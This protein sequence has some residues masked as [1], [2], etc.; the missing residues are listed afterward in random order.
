MTLGA[1]LVRTT[2]LF[3][4]GAAIML[5]GS[6]RKSVD[7]QR[8]RAI[9]FVGFFVIV[10]AVVLFGFAGTPGLLAIAIAIVLGGAVEARRAWRLIPAPRPSWLITAAFAASA[11]FIYVSSRADQAAVVWIFMVT[12]SFDG[13]GQVIGQL[14]GRRPLVPNISPAK[15]V[16]GLAGAIV[17]AVFVAVWLRALPGYDVGRTIVVALAIGV[18][19]LIGDLLGSW[20]KRRAGIK[21]FSSVLPGQGG[22]I[23]RFNSFVSAMALVGVWL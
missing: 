1:L 2:A 11:V 8:A 19:S 15:T 22:V 17:G 18:A 4:L 7:V 20:T 10:H 12:A 14:I 6:F 5:L 13:F 21:D 16:E 9:K 3:V 23:D